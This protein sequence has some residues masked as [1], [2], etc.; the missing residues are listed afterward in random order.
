[1]VLFPVPWPLLRSIVCPLPQR[2]IPPAPFCR[3]P[4]DYLNVIGVAIGLAGGV[5]FTAAGLYR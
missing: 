5:V 1:M 3:D 4:I 2:L